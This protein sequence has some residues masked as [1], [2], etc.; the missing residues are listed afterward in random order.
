MIT[1][2]DNYTGANTAADIQ[3]TPD[4]KF[5]YASNRG[6][7]NIAIFRLDEKT[8][9]LTYIGQISSHGKHPRSIA[10]DKLGEYL[11]VTNRDTDNLILMKID[12]NTGLLRPTGTELKIPGAVVVKH[13]II[14]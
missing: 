12:K 4:G 11:F 3:V 5:V 2:A 6:L 13:L 9:E 8:P 14:K 7:D 1:D 10:M